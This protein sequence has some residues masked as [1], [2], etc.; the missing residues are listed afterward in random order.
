MVI[1][2]KIFKT[3]KTILPEYSLTTSFFKVTNRKKNRWDMYM[4]L[5]NSACACV[6]LVFSPARTKQTA[7]TNKQNPN[8]SKK[9]ENNNKNK[10]LKLLLFLLLSF[11][12]L[13]SKINRLGGNNLSKN[14]INKGCLY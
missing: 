9:I 2:K 12:N 14:E 4:L 13:S 1:R 11:S 6:F 7:T 3:S 10:M 5:T 8:E